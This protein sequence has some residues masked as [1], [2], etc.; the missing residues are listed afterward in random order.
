MS[1]IYN[2]FCYKFIILIFFTNFRSKE[3]TVL[4]NKDLIFQMHSWLNLFMLLPSSWDIFHCS[5][6]HLGYLS[7][8]FGKS[9]A[10]EFLE[11]CPVREPQVSSGSAITDGAVSSGGELPLCKYTVSSGWLGCWAHPK[12]GHSSDSLW[13]LTTNFFTRALSFLTNFF[14]LSFLQR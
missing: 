11:G 4:Y 7:L 8:F 10:K 1:F 9:F 13:T 3:Q 14:F 2:V 5:I 12:L 6:F